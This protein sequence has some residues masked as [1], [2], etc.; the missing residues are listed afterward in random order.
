VGAGWLNGSNFTPS[1]AGNQL[2]MWQADTFDPATIDRELGWAASSGMNSARVF[3]HDLLWAD[4]TFPDR[5]DRFLDIAAGHGVRPLFVLFDGIWDPNPVVGRQREP[6]PGVHNS[7]WLQ[8]PG[9]AV[10]AD[11][12]RWPL[13][14]PYVEGM[15]DRFGH[16]ERV[17]GWDLFNEPDSPNPAY[18]KQEVRG[19]EELIAE[20]LDEIFDW[21]TAV[22]PDQ[23]LTAGVYSYLGPKPQAARPSAR[24]ML[25]RSDVVSFHCY[26]GA[27][28]LGRVIDGLEPLGRPILCTEWMGRPGSPVE[29]LELLARRDVGAYCWGLVDGRTQTRY[30]WTSWWRRTK[31]GAT[32][33]HELF[34]PDGTPYDEAE[35][36]LW[37]RVASEKV[38]ASEAG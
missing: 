5:V 18:R 34:H 24:V 32:W 20:L 13:L 22:D 33:F 28:R 35:M 9:A 37:R 36:A 27:D 23:P 31:P 7:I 12:S 4:A 8:S 26:G 15:V 11:R 10:L 25:E 3:L 1:T 17:V 21:A 6:R 38:T 16:D 2:E 14:R 30:P 19:K 29:L